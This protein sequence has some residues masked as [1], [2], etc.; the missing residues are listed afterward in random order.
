[1]SVSKLIQEFERR[2]GDSDFVSPSLLVQIGV[3]GSLTAMHNALRKGL[4][5]HIR[6]SR[7]RVLIPRQSVVDHLYASAVEANSVS[8]KQSGGV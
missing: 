5:P 6:I 4:I 7:N 3:F 2:L 1:M 8:S